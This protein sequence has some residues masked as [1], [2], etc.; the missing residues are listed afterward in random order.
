METVHD[1]NDIRLLTVVD[2]GVIA[3]GK[4]GASTLLAS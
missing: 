2:S 4:K 1:L 3:A